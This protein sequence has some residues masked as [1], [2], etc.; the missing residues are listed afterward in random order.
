MGWEAGFSKR[1]GVRKILGRENL[2]R[3]HCIL[4]CNQKSVQRWEPRKMGQETG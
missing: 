1:V 2:V 4:F 3:Q